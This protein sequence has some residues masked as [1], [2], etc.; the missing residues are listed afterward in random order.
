M[1]SV[2]ESIIEVLKSSK[3]KLEPVSKAGII[4]LRKK[5]P[6][7]CE[8][9]FKLTEGVGYVSTEH[10]PITHEPYRLL[11]GKNC[12]IPRDFE[13]YKK[14]LKVR[15]SGTHFVPLFKPSEMFVFSPSGSSWD[16]CLRNDRTDMVY[17][18]DW[19]SLEITSNNQNLFDFL[20]E[21]LAT[22]LDKH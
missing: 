1:K 5:F 18:I 11:H 7:L 16:Y 6:N 20:F 21:F 19:V 4:D 13:D 2:P 12:P 22:Q 9:F 17:T 3:F 8:Q 10:W 15:N 14:E